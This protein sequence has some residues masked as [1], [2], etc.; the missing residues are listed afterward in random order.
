MP[1]VIPSGGRHRVSCVLP[2]RNE[3]EAIGTVVPAALD[4]LAALTDESEVVV[5]DDGSTD[6]TGALLDAL[7]AQEPRLRVIHFREPR[8]YGAAL[9]AGFAASRLPVLMFTDSDGQFDLRD[10][11]R[12]LPLL[13]DADLVVGFR[14]DRADPA[15]RRVLSRGYNALVR[16]LLGVRVR[17]MNCAF[18][19][20]HRRVLDL[21][22]LESDGYAI[23]AELVA[24]ADAAGLRVREVGVR[25]FPRIAGESKVGA[26]NVPG[27]LRQL[28][29]LRSLL[30]ADRAMPRSAT[31]PATARDPRA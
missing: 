7:A 12:L 29:T 26:T 1:G 6:R 21:F 8:G 23:N 20:F 5:V 31:T 17:D 10:L 24:R 22:P 3:E 18:K 13:A 4:A 28:W 11:G 9:Q 14:V 15:S 27:A 30:T 16:L 25:H 2:A 19:A